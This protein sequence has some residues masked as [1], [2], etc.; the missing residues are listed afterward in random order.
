ME[1]TPVYQF[2]NHERKHKEKAVDRRG[3]EIDKDIFH[4]VPFRIRC[5][6]PVITNLILSLGSWE[7]SE[8]TL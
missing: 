6:P 3:P 7:V 8:R 1:V 5:L 2:K 4:G